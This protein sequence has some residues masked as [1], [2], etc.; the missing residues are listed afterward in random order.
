[1]PPKGPAA[2]R[3]TVRGG[4]GNRSVSPVKGKAG[5]TAVGRGSLKKR[6]EKVD[7][8]EEAERLEKERQTARDACVL[9][10]KGVLSR[11]TDG[12]GEEVDLDFI[13][14]IEDS[15][16]EVLKWIEQPIGASAKKDEYDKKVLVVEKAFSDAVAKTRE[17]RAE[18]PM[19]YNIFRNNEV[20]VTRDGRQLEAAVK[21]G[22]LPEIVRLLKSQRGRAQLINVDPRGWTPLHYAVTLGFSEVTEELIRAGADVNAQAE[23]GTSCMHLACGQGRDHM[24]QVL[25]GAGALTGLEIKENQWTPLHI[26]SSNGDIKAVRALLDAKADANANARG[27]WHPLHCAAM[28]GHA[29]VAALLML[30]R[31]VEGESQADSKATLELLTG[32]GTH[33]VA[34]LPAADIAKA[35]GHFDCEEKIRATAM[36][37]QHEAEEAN[38]PPQEEP[39]PEPTKGR[40]GRGGTRAGTTSK[41]KTSKSSKPKEK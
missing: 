26:A 34:G 19:P 41:S 40:R 32:D 33:K 36:F 6:A 16:N 20:I 30:P 28:N 29:D 9:Q 27:D 18:P 23:D 25:V 8:K 3:G 13:I 31:G 1:M 17:K 5:S 10:V 22:D 21:E 37:L 35:H 15:C 24:I 4:A 12:S 14:D 7:P 38:K 39:E 2:A 11:V